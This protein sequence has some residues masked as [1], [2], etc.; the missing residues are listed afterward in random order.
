MGRP[1]AGYIVIMIAV[2]AYEAFNANTDMQ[3]PPKCTS[4][5]LY[6]VLGFCV[7]NI[8]F[9]FL[10][11]RLVWWEIM[12]E[13]NFPEFI[14]GDKPTQGYNEGV[15][16]AVGGAAAQAKA[17]LNSQKK[18]GGEKEREEFGMNPGKII[19]PTK[20]VQGAFSKVFL[21]NL[22]V[23]AMFLL[24]IG[25][26][27]LSFMGPASVDKGIDT[28]CSVTG[29]TQTVGYAFFVLPAVWSFLYMKC[30]CCANKVTLS[31]EEMSNYDSSYKYEDVAE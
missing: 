13:D 21:E 26:A 28:P 29:S 31:K 18:G 11:Q 20:V 15:A 19:I 3:T 23:L 7:I 9:A 27:V 12:R 2:S 17:L 25:M 4:Y 6:I 5:Y 16:G 1:L 10:L 14:D 24:L 8:L 30:N 22:A